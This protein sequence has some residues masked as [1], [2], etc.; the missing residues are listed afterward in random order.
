MALTIDRPTD[1]PAHPRTHEHRARPG[2]FTPAALLPAG[3]V[4][5]I[6]VAAPF[7]GTTTHALSADSRPAAV[8]TTMT[9]AADGVPATNAPAAANTPASA[10][11]QHV[12]T[13]GTP[14]VSD[15]QNVGDAQNVDQGFS[16]TV[17]PAS[18]RNLVISYL[19][20]TMLGAAVII[21]A[22][23]RSTHRR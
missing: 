23:V 14:S 13:A 7:A 1:L 17:P 3:L 6:L 18:V 22:A 8:T 12:A 4:S 20:I 19:L 15:T 10:D 21:T 11:A 5:A 16:L 9:G 2:R